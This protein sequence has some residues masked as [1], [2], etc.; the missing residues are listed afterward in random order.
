MNIFYEE[1]GGF[2]A[3][4]VLADQGGALQVESST[5]KRSKVKI[6][7]VLL[8]F[9][10][11]EPAA[12]LRDAHALADQIDLDFLWECAPQD[13]FGFSEMGEDYLVISRL[14][15]NLPRSRRGCTARRCISIA[16]AAAATRRHPRMR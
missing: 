12:L 2:K 8:E 6:S 4:R 7:N 9:R 5:G 14:R 16:R 15:S 13:E 3:G 11:P 1:D 10:E